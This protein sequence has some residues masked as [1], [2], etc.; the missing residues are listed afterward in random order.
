LGKVTGSRAAGWAIVTAAAVL[1]LFGTV[2]VAAQ[3]KGPSVT[4]TSTGAKVALLGVPAAAGQQSNG[5]EL[6][7][8][9]RIFSA[10]GIPCDVLS[11]AGA[12]DAYRVVFTAG[13][14]SNSR[15]VAGL[16]N[17]LYDY[18][19]GGGVLVSAG[20]VGSDLYPLFGVEKQ[21]PSRKRF[22][23]SFAGQDP[24]LSYLTHP[25]Q[26]TISLGNG[27]PP[28]Y[29]EVIW[30][31]GACLAA[32]ATALGLFEDGTAAFSVHP[33][34]RGKAYLLGL[35]YIEAVLLPQV[36][37]SFNAQRQYVNGIEPS[38]DSI[39]LLLKAIWASNDVPSVCLASIPY[40]LTT[41]LV[42]THDV[43]A[44]T[45]FVD[46]LKFAALEKSYGAKSTFFVTTK[47]FT[48][49]SDI[50]YFNVPENVEALR[51]LKSQGWDI[52]SHTVSHSLQL[53]SAPDGD[54][55]VTRKTYDPRSRLTVWGEVK[56]SKELLDETIAG[57]NTI[58]YRSGDL[59]FPR[60]LIRLLQGCGYRYDSTYS[61]NAVLSAFPFVALEDQAVD[62]RESRV[63][64]IPLT[65]DDSQDFLTA[66][67][68]P[69][70]VQKWTEVL[71][72]N[73]RYGGITVLLMHPSDT[74]TQ[75]YKLQAQ[76]GLMKELVAMGGWMGD[77]SAFGKFW[78]SRAALRFSTRCGSGGALVIQVEAREADLDPSLGFEVGGH[79]GNIIVT[80]SQ[81][82]PLDFTVVTRNGRLY[83]TRAREGQ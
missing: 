43:D 36:G 62:A 72:A 9:R 60:S 80:D 2:P 51:E 28:F 57:Q 26:L 55:A 52:G 71:R 23:L 77:L 25:R 69:T 4:E 48:D 14:L 61:A 19:E 29:D 24:S 46:S 42:L 49:A 59:A 6:L 53:A 1:A 21:V 13:A 12:L 27:Q 54:P 31:H 79:A 83:L 15:L 10:L 35:S 65:L 45:S 47:T 56:V 17:D 41:A 68:V 67:N 37:G 18:V 11:S 38:V 66:E 81:G 39:M 78:T 74:R 22:R 70:A 75:T 44:Q 30:S 73:A 32:E 34:G 40:A 64:E 58:A 50:G 16:A 20:E 5:I 33:Y 8:L 7:A 63:V 3:Q 82:R 76:E